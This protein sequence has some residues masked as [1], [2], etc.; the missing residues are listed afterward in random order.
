LHVLETAVFRKTYSVL[1]RANMPFAVRCA[2]TESFSGASQLQSS[3]HSSVSRSGHFDQSI[4]T[5]E[6][7]HW[8]A[9]LVPSARERTGA[10]N[11]RQTAIVSTTSYSVFGKKTPIGT[12]R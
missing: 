7:Q 12:C 6:L 2:G 4:T 8:P 1:G 9:R 11:F 3:M 10:E 5:A